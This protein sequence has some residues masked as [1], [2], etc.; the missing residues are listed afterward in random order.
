MLTAEGA[1]SP[2]K[3]TLLIIGAFY[4]FDTSAARIVPN[5]QAREMPNCL[6][7]HIMDVYTLLVLSITGT[8][9]S[10]HELVFTGSFIY[11][12]RML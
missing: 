4:K 6:P 5:I 3:L 10:I 2:S 12:A 7:L 8:Y 11:V 1:D 9:K